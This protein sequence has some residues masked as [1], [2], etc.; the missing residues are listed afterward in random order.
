MSKHQLLFYKTL[1]RVLSIAFL[2][3]TITVS[4]DAKAAHEIEPLHRP[5]Y[6]N[7]RSTE[8]H[9]SLDN[10][11]QLGYSDVPINSLD[12]LEKLPEWIEV[13]LPASI[14]W[15]LYRAGKL[16]Y[17]YANLNSKKYE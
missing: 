14:H 8:Q 12:E 16:P 17:P 6:I 13:D 10:A 4:S 2:V 11:W 3:A 5:V 7:P 1:H 15:A 9:L